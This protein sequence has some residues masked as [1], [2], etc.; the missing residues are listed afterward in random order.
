MA[1]SADAARSLEDGLADRAVGREL[2]AAINA[3]TTSIANIANLGGVLL[4]TQTEIDAV[5]DV[6]ARA[7]VNVTTA[8]LAITAILHSNKPIVLNS[9][10]TQTI[11]LPQATGTGNIYRFRVGLTGT[12]GS[13]IIQ[14]ANATDILQGSSHIVQTD[15]TQVAGFAT[16][17][18]DDTITLNNTT[19]GG[20]I[21]DSIEITDILT[22]VF[23][24]KILGKAT[25]TVLTPFSAAVP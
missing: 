19:K 16:T 10:H 14:V 12:D 3:A 21:G 15:L 7:S 18:T 11:T 17:A 25:G 13:K 5:A 20:Y 22:G 8:T 9:T 23:T 1:L 2:V 4:A 6:S 24:V